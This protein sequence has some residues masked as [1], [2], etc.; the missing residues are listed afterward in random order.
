MRRIQRKRFSSLAGI[1]FCSTLLLSACSE[2]E[3]DVS[4]SLLEV[5]MTDQSAIERG[6]SIFVG[7]CANYCHGDEPE[8]GEDVDLFDCQ[9]SY[10]SSSEDIFRIVTTGIPGTRMVGF[11]NNFPEGQND[12]WKLIAY[13]RTQQAD[14]LPAVTEIIEE[15]LVN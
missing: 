6:Y 8:Q 11:G 3:P 14:C 12:L 7:S 5:Y 2:T 4:M 10:G 1:L 15:E 9:S 13:I